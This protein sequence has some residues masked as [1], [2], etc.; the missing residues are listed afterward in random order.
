MGTRAHSF[1]WT[2]VPVTHQERSPCTTLEK[3]PAREPWFPVRLRF[4][5]R[6]VCGS[7]G[8]SSLRVTGTGV[9]SNEWALVPTQ[10][11]DRI[12]VNRGSTGLGP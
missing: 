12:Y 7:T 1:E 8:T 9:H 4:P 11:A 6:G 5:V 10:N 3:Q 2:L